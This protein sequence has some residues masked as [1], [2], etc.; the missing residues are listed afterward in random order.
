MDKIW[1]LKHLGVTPKPRMEDAE[2]FPL[3]LWA[4]RV[5]HPV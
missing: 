2:F 1:S 3:T 4:E 5:S